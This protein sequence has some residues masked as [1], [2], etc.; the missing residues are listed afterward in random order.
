MYNECEGTFSIKTWATL[1]S[2]D[3][4]LAYRSQDR[5]TEQCSATEYSPWVLANSMQ[6]YLVLCLGISMYTL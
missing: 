6:Y 1:A 2:S 3:N 4:I 5:A